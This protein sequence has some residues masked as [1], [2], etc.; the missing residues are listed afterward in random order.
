MEPSDLVQACVGGLLLPLHYL[1]QA[2]S[3]KQLL[4]VHCC[5]D[6]LS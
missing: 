2:E 5:L 6:L 1:L 4:Y 3:Y